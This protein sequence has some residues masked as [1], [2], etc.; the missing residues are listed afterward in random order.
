MNF[1]YIFFLLFIQ[2]FSKNIF[3]QQELMLHQMPNVWHKNSLNPA[4]FPDD[5][6]I[7]IGLPSLTLD[8][9]HSGN[10]SLNDF[11]VKQ[12]GTNYYDLSKVLTQ[13]E[14][15][16]SFDIQERIETVSFGIKLAGWGLSIGHAIRFS[17]AV[18]YPKSMAQLFWE[19]N[20]KFI[21]Q[22]V[23]IAP[24]INFW[25]CNELGLGISKKFLN[26][27]VGVRVK[28]L[29][30]IGALRTD[31]AHSSASVF[32][33]SDIYQLTLKTDYAFQSA[34]VVSAFDTSG[35][36][37]DIKTDKLKIGRLFSKN[38]GIAFDLGATFKL[39]DKIQV[40]ASLL[41]LGGSI[42]WKDNANYYKSQGSYKY[43]GIKIPGAD[44]INAADSLSIEGQLDSL[45]DIFQFQKTAQTF[46][47]QL[48]TRIYIGAQV[49]ITKKLAVG[50][51]VYRL[52]SKEKSATAFG[53]N[54]QITPIKMLSFG[55][56]YSTN[57]KSKTN[58]GLNVIVRPGPVQLYFASDNI[59]N[60]VSGNASPSV[61]FRVG[62]GLV[63]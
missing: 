13:L 12:N 29:S 6:H 8:Q 2:F 53:L 20:G 28:Y 23:E 36:G 42:R 25:G 14:P 5:K 15:K 59:L 43:E 11:I 49:Q 30:G 40:Q 61:N 52:Q 55:A 62:A 26:T 16:N 4:W 39:T 38:S 32:T 1:K 46:N 31:D 33:D 17:G 41:D 37:Y 48:P 22:T 51:S 56:M 58:L 57:D 7:A 9:F 63:F 18:E 54:A 3:A 50:A 45:N 60:G 34:A 47:T 44:I 19:G 10:I 24:K 27:R 35:F 21:G